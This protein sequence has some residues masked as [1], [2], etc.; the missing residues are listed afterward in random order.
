M[1]VVKSP[2]R[3]RKPM[4][5]MLP[6]VRLSAPVSSFMP[7]GDSIK[8]TDSNVLGTLAVSTMMAALCEYGSIFYSR[9]AIQMSIFANS[10]RGFGMEITQISET[11]AHS[12][13]PII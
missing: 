1:W 4:T 9:P 3:P 7:S 5:S 10:F 6:A 2:P 13:T 8:G 11:C 12:M